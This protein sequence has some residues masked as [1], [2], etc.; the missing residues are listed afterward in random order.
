[1]NEKAPD[2]TPPTKTKEKAVKAA[3]EP[4]PPKEA[5]APKE[6]KVRATGK[7]G[8][9]PNSKIEIVKEKENKYRG[10]RLAWFDL[11]K[12]FDGKLVV[13]FNTAAKG[14]LN[15]KGKEQ[16]PSGWLRFYA[17]DG[18]VKLHPQEVPPATA[19]QALAA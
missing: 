9:G 3:K 5:K 17:L 15:G 14:R 11:L 10:Q 4:K 8:Y 2:L 7:Y 19:G 12:T 16:N 13:E 6:K 18:S 1:M